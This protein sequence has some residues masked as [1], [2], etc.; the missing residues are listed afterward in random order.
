VWVSVC[1]ASCCIIFQVGA[2]PV[3]VRVY[4]KIFSCSGS[5]T[6]AS[7]REIL[8]NRQ[9]AL[10][11]WWQELNEGRHTETFPV[12]LKASRDVTFSVARSRA[13]VETAAETTDCER[14][15]VSLRI[16]SRWR[17]ANCSISSAGKLQCYYKLLF[18][19]SLLK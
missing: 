2:V 17:P 16:V 6:W 4:R 12:R 7:L 9:D 18:T 14:I 15:I 10:V 19:F 1:A 3:C 8:V 11:A 5:E 13:N